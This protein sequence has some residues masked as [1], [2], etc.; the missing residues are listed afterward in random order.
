MSVRDILISL[1]V[2]NN[3]DWEKIYEDIRNKN[4]IEKEEAKK[5]VNDF[6]AKHKKVITL[7]D[8]D[9]PERLKRTFKPPFVI[10]KD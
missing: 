6:T 2:K 3:G 8:D 10:V 1:Y 9:Y 7:L 4:T 5:M